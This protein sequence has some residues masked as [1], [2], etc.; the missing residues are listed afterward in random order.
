M[1]VAP[2]RH[3][4]GLEELDQD[5]LLELMTLAR[6]SIE[7]LRT[8]MNPDGFN[9]GMNLGEVAGAGIADHLHLHVVPRWEGDNNFMPVLADTHVVPQAL[10]ATR[11]ALVEALR[12]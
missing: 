9:V 3:V 8:A 6:R 11:E 7:A 5:E 10:E 1:L 2:T 4:A 12:G